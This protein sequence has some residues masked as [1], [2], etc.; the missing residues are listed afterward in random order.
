MT[1]LELGRPAKR[2]AFLR[3]VL[4]VVFLAAMITGGYFLVPKFEWHKPQIK[5]TPDTDTIGLAPVEI[6]ISEKGTGLKSATVTL[7]VAGTERPL[8]SEQYAQPVTETKFTVASSK[9][10]GVKEGPALFRI[11]ARDRSLWSFFRG[12]ETVVQKNVTIDITPPTVELIA[13]DP[14][15][16]FGGCGLI[17]Y[18]PSADTE[19][20]GVKIGNYFFPGYKGQTK[21]P[22][23]YI[24][25]FAHPYNV[26]EDEKA[27]LIA[28]DKAGNSRQMRLAYT[29]KTVKYK[30]STIAITDD[31]I[32]GKV[33][34]LLN[35][36]GARQGN[37]KDVFL[38]VN[39]DLRNENETKIR[40]VTQKSASSMLWSGPFNQLSNSKV[41]ANFADARTYTYQ[42]T[43]IDTAYHVG[44]DLSVTKHYPVEAANSGT[45][46]F[47]GDLGIYGNTVIIDHGLGLFT[48]YSH[49][50]SIEVKAGD[51][52]KK[53]QIIAKT[54]ETGLAAGD[55]L[56]FGVYLNGVAVLPIEWWDEK[57]LRDNV[58]PKLE[59][60]ESDSR[61]EAQTEPKVA[62]K[63]TVRRRR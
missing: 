24:A 43:V 48:L 49:L 17:V 7:S 6:A 33:A 27:V 30:K 28:T 52:I 62:S 58:N 15:I 53:A 38:K 47:V 31:F 55:H 1:A 14:Y 60:S 44:F 45:V 21:D 36:V 40:R 16:N 57:W 12:N 35:D 56:H 34:P 42:N 41:E 32:Q 2:T 20:S 11:T 25:F 61:A 51:P 37:P 63:R 9:L 13:D 22:N 4:A 46:A 26:A 3:N 39:R 8:F 59:S 18:K 50:S 5:I 10:T 23:A 29:L 54:G 19:I